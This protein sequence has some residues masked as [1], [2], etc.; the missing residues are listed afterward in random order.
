MLRRLLVASFAVVIIAGCGSGG[1][2]ASPAA[3]GPAS[4]AASTTKPAAASSE[5]STPA[6]DT[7]P[8][9]TT[10]ST[11]C[12]AVGIR[13]LP[14]SKGALIVR[15]AAGTADG[16]VWVWSLESPAPLSQLPA[17]VGEVRAVGFP[18]EALVFVGGDRRVHSVPRP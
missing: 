13:K 17:D 11:A 14:S 5:A 18:G 2:T 4:A 3:S 8:P 16:Q 1:P 12:A 15:L 9:T 6:L 7:V 10:M